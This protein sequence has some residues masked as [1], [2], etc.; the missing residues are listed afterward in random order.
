MGSKISGGIINILVDSDISICTQAGD[1]SFTDSLEI[2]FQ[3]ISEAKLEVTLLEGAASS[4]T[5]AADLVV[6]LKIS[7][8]VS[9]YMNALPV[10][11]R[12]LRITVRDRDLARDLG[13]E[14]VEPRHFKKA[15]QSKETIAIVSGFDGAVYPQE[16]EVIEDSNEERTIFR[17]LTRPREKSQYD[18]QSVE[19]NNFIEQSPQDNQ[20]R[21]PDTQLNP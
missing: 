14:F 15:S 19:V 8:E 9:C 3:L 5:S 18:A 16:N 10:K 2:P 20:T 17:T 7:G 21:E 1:I 6:E 13:R 11:I 4:A 12:G